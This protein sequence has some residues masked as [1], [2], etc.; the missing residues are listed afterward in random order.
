M[1]KKPRQ[2]SGLCDNSYARYWEKRPT[3][4]YKAL[5]RRQVDVPLRGT[6]MTSGN[7]QK[8]L[9]LSFPTLREFIA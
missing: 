3:Q 2:E 7:Q 1:Y 9:F 5:L 8:H 4:I 6:D